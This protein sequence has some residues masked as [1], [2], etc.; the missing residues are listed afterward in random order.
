MT[1]L[2]P[3][4][5]RPPA[6][7]FRL[8]PGPLFRSPAVPADGLS[9]RSGQP[10]RSQTNVPLFDQVDTGADPA[11]Q[12]LA[13][14]V[15]Y[16]DSLRTRENALVHVLKVDPRRADLVPVFDQRAKSLEP[17][18]LANQGLLAAINANFFTGSAIIGDLKDGGRIWRDDALPAVDRRSDHWYHVGITQ[19]GQVETGNGGL[20]ETGH[21]TRFRSFMGGFPQLFSR[22]QFARLD[23]D[24]ASGAFARRMPYH[25]ANLTDAI[26]RSFLGVTAD[27]QVLLLATGAGEQRSKGATL[28][29][30]ARLLRGLGAV[31]AYI[32]DGG[33]STSMMVQGRMAAGTDGRKVKAYLG[34][35]PR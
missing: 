7:L 22:S 35:R 29:E 15:W 2:V 11:Y 28:E 1:G 17:A 26:S 27:G 4:S 32:L 12:A 33:G 18:A 3:A 10:T 34:I 20:S 16:S 25:G 14:G 24:I 30:A 21:E 13:K 6:E 19:D 8:P 5:L 23:A 9:L 31:E